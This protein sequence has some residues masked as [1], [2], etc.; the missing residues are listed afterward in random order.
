MN[1]FLDLFKA[2]DCLNHKVLL[3]TLSMYGIR[4]IT[5]D[6]FKNYLHNQQ[7]FEVY[8]LI[9]SKYKSISHGVPQGSI[10]APLLFLLYIDNICYTSDKL[11]LILF[12]DDT[13]FSMAYKKNCLLLLMKWMSNLLKYKHGWN[14]I[15]LFWI[16][17]SQIWWFLPNIILMLPDSKY[18]WNHLSNSLEYYLMISCHGVN[19]L[20]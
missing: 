1:L 17:Q 15:D 3:R 7:Q 20:M 5:L 11:N 2:F 14:F 12:A 9:S 19:M 10:L 4:G 6:W 13:T 18:L 16:H 8:N